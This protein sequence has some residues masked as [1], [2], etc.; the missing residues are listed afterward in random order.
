MMALGVVLVLGLIACIYSAPE[1]TRPLHPITAALINGANPES[2]KAGPIVDL[3]DVKDDEPKEKSSGSTTV[4]KGD[5]DR[6]LVSDVIESTLSGVH[7]GFAIGGNNGTIDRLCIK[8]GNITMAGCRR[9]A[10]QDKKLSKDED[11]TE[12][13][14]KKEM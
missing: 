6:G 2:D 1:T 11:K 13:P 14:E 8:L 9:T 3:P 7:L 4:K 5:L 10:S 12:T